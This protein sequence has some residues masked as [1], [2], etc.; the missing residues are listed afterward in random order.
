MEMEENLERYHC[1]M[2]LPEFGKTSQHLLQAAKV[3]IVGMGGLGCPAAQYLTAAGIGTIGIADDDMISLSNLHRQILY[4]PSEVGL[5]KTAVACQKLQQQNPDIQLIAHPVRVTS[6]NVMELIANYDLIVEGTD[7]FETKFLL[8][9]AC[10]LAGKPLVYGAIYQ[11]EGQVSIWNVLQQDGSRSVN[12]RDVFPDAE[13]AQI[14][15]CSEGGVIPTL[16]GIVGCMQANEVIKYFTRPEDLLA[17]KLWLMNMMSGKTSIIKLK[18]QTSVQISNLKE[19]VKSI[20]WEELQGKTSQND[21]ILI[22]VRSKEEHLIFNIGGKN[23]PLDHL[24]NHWNEIKDFQEVIFYCA[25]GNR[26]SKAVRMI[27]E[28]FPDLKAYSLKNGIEQYKRGL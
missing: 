4:T 5:S 25:S 2:A 10:V 24:E 19:S 12:Y 16:A 8:N 15:N 28:L 7:N 1:Q 26:S 11:Y 23:L 3:L 20:T 13:N 18:K 14:P 6:D 21:R 9:D 27:K 22:D 17:G